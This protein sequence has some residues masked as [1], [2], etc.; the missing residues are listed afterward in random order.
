MKKTLAILGGLMLGAMLIIDGNT[1]RIKLG[2]IDAYD[3]AQQAIIDTEV[4][5]MQILADVERHKITEDS[6]KLPVVNPVG[7]HY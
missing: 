5:R 7:R 4:R 2:A 1:A 3:R 6:R